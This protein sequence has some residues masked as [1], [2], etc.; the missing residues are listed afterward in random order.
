M[1]VGPG[2]GEKGGDI[3]FGSRLESAANRTH[4]EYV[5]A[6]RDVEGGREKQARCGSKSGASLTERCANDW[7]ERW[8]S[9]GRE[10]IVPRA[11][12]QNLRDRSSVAGC[13]RSSQRKERA[14]QEGYRLRPGLAVTGKA[15]DARDQAAVR[16]GR[17]SGG[18]A[19]LVRAR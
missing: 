17:T 11:G 6:Q 19:D 4:T 16:G 5:S 1:G 14:M 3:G 7:R 12:A 18:Q 13:R 10:S 15:I 9:T 2:R 8:D